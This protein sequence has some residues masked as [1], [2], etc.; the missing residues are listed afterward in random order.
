MALLSLYSWS[1]ASRAFFN[2]GASGTETYEVFVPFPQNVVNI[3][4]GLNIS[5]WYGAAGREER[6]K[7]QNGAIVP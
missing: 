7:P 2:V 6:R 4:G 1:L 5:A 3:T